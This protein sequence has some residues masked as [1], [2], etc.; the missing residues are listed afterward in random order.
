MYRSTPRCLLFHEFGVKQDR[1]CIKHPSSKYKHW[2]KIANDKGDCAQYQ[3][4]NRNRKS[5]FVCHILI[6]F[7][8]I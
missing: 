6:V 2:L 5:S 3:E 1:C 7:S 8:D 4:H